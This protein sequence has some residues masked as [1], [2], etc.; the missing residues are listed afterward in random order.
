MFAGVVLVLL[1]QVFDA[2]A[3]FEEF[4]VVAC[5]VFVCPVLEVLREDAGF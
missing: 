1:F 2:M 5:Q 4:F 3:E